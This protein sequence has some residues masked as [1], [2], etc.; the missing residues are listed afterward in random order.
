[1]CPWSHSVQV[2]ESKLKVVYLASKPMFSTQEI[3]TPCESSRRLKTEGKG[4]MR[5][6]LGS[7][8]SV[9]PSPQAA[10]EGLQSPRRE[11]LSL[12][13]NGSGLLLRKEGPCACEMIQTCTRL[14]GGGLSYSVTV[15]PQITWKW[16]SFKNSCL[17]RVWEACFIPG[18]VTSTGVNQQSICKRRLCCWFFLFHSPAA[19]LPVHPPS[20]CGIHYPGKDMLILFNWASSFQGGITKNRARV[21]LSLRFL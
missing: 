12:Q 8:I 14:T 10:E 2:I 20:A 21:S 16:K 9:A 19:L 13:W 7:C 18:L 3:A 4:W 1:M 5:E 6:T 11:A 17:P 15:G